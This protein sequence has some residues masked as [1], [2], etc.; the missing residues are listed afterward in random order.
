MSA[1]AA[2]TPQRRTQ[3]ERSAATREALLDAT[4]QCLVED[5]YA[6]TTTSQVAL[7][8]G[9]SRGAH[10]H[11]FQT[12]NALIAAAL[13]QLAR[14]RHAEALAAAD[15]LPAGPERLP[16]ALDIIW[17]FYASRLFQ[18]ALDLWAHARTDPE[19]RAQLVPIERE[20]DRQTMELVRRMFPDVAARPDFEPLVELS[21]ATARGLSLLD[22]LHP[23]SDRS[24][25]QWEGFRGMLVGLFEAGA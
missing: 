5:G 16:A 2:P 17:S 23:G 14:K 10:L 11:H 24:R 13:E 15:R 25:R 9:L 22:M 8:A 1:A 20:L 21:I 3:A 6:G 4:I 12:R 18:A 19:L 7:R